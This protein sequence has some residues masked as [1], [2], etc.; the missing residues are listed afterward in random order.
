MK[1]EDNEYIEHDLLSTLVLPK[2]MTLVDFKITMSKVK[3]DIMKDIEN[4][5]LD[6]HTT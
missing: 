5:L 1:G 6:R 3:L 4:N 2:W